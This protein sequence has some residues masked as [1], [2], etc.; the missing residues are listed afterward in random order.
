MSGGQLTNGQRAAH[1]LDGINAHARSSAQQE[2][3]MSEERFFF[4]FDRDTEPGTDHARLA[5]LLRDLQHYA[6]RRGLDFDAAF[7]AARRDYE[8]QRTTYQPGDAIRLAGRT[9][10]AAA[11]GGFPLVGEI[12]KAR[13]GRL[14]EYQVE[15]IT[16]R[17]WI[18][19]PELE[20]APRFPGIVTRF[21]Q[22]S[23]AHAARWCFIQTAR[24]AEEALSGAQR[25]RSRGHQGSRPAPGR[26]EPMVGHRASRAPAVLQRG[27][28]REGR[29]ARRA[30]A[31][32]EP[33]HPRRARHACPPRHE[34][35][36]RRPAVTADQGGHA[37]AGHRGTV[38]GPE[39]AM[40]GT[41]APAGAAAHA[42]GTAHPMTVTRRRRLD[43]MPAAA[44]QAN[45]RPLTHHPPRGRYLR[46]EQRP[47]FSW[48]GRQLCQVPPSPAGYR[49]SLRSARHASSS[50]R[51]RT[52][53]APGN[54]R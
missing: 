7:A 25:P 23:S 14:P 9:G 18:A 10:D 34:P 41:P 43:A 32:P 13:P 6:S 15:F 53:P 50:P 19:E 36:S 45:S 38:P 4:D 37:G 2:P 49:I 27:H 1:A 5:D 51:P 11:A 40:N 21:G 47:G 44:T 20:A 33:R 28:R 52:Q 30:A 39:P 22:V 17:Q 12:I 46:P 54:S 16:R 31:R 42:A 35:A 48:K 29:A 8:V 3:G 26:A 24:Q